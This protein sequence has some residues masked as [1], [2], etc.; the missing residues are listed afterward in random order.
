MAVEIIEDKPDPS[1]LRQVVCRNCGRKLQYVLSDVKSKTY[2]DISGTRDTCHW[3]ECPG[4][5]TNVT[6]KGH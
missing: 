4:C 6:V 3:I 5:N 1:A 2:S